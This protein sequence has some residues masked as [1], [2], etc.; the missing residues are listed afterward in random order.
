MYGV[1]PDRDCVYWDLDDL[2]ATG[3]SFDPTGEGS[4]P[5]VNEAGI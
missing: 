3:C 1:E 5:R 4:N 2:D